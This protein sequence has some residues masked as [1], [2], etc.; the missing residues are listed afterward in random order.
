MIKRKNHQVQNVKKQTP[1]QD[2][3]EASSTKNV[4]YNTEHLNINLHC[5][6]K[7]TMDYYQKKNYLNSETA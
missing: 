4:T 6:S 2:K 1:K 7:F 3:T 5:E